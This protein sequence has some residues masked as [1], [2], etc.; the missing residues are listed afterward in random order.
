MAKYVLLDTETTGASEEDRII[1][2][3]F[4][5]LDGK[6]VE[7]YNDLCL[8]PIPI[9]YGAMEVHGITP[10]MI[11]GKALCSETRAFQTLSELNTAENVLIIHNAPFDLGMLSKESFTS[12]MRL[13]DT[14]R[15]ARHLFDD[16]ESHRLQYF[17][18]RFGLYKIEQAE[19]DALGI[20]V[21]AHD[22][23]GDV[24]VLKLFL[25][26]LR[27]RLQE[28]FAGVN[29]IDKMVELTQTPVFYTRPLKFG[30][31][32]GKTLT[33]IADADRGYLTWMLGNM[34]SL[35]EDMRYSIERVLAS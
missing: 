32:K 22:A 18:Y 6:S 12:Q 26:E 5:V 33:E 21:K 2:L 17:R 28:R 20:E 15:C 11:E 4:M 7:V 1:Q 30:K 14:L 23:I 25:T 27:K 29:P 19:A 24:L 3:G 8:A 31:Y 10:E 35:D 16:E 13:I 9:G 34:D